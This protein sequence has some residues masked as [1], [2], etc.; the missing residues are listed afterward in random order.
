MVMDEVGATK[1]EARQI[2]R[3]VKKSARKMKAFR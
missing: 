2:V 3:A 1:K